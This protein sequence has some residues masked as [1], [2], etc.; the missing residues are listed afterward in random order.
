[1]PKLNRTAL[2]ERRQHIL[3]AATLCFARNGFHR[4]TIADVCKEAGVSTGAI[5]TYFP[6]KQ[7]IVRAMLRDAQAERRAQLERATHNS[8]PQLSQ[9]AVLLGW[10]ADVFSSHGEHVSRVEVN[11]WAEA[12]RNR[13]VA[14]LVTD[15]INEATDSVARVIAEILRGLKPN[16]DFDSRALASLLVSVYL[17][18]EVQTALNVQIRPDAI[19]NM[20]TR[21]VTSAGALPPRRP[22]RAKGS[23]KKRVE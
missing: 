12:V 21:L 15:A 11:L 10:V 5:Y 22:A 6:N 4:T 16:C 3:Q 23:G 14:Q 1:M 7:A 20:M 9:A 17:G 13:H 2:E 18:L 8:D 19:V